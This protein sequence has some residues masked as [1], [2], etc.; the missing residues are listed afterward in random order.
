MIRTWKIKHPL[1]YMEAAGR[2]ERQGGRSEV[3]PKERAFEFLMNHLRLPE[4][5]PEERFAERTGLATDALE[6]RL[7]AC[8]EDGLL[9]R[10]RGWIRC[11]EIGFAFLDDVLQRFL[12]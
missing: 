7:S 4:G 5:F 2:P 8:L 6:P 3:A 1:H 11:T 9:E 10:Q 12:D